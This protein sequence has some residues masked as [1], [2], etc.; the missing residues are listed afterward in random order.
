MSPSLTGIRPCEGVGDVMVQG[1]WNGP[2]EVPVWSEVLGVVV[3][4]PG[5]PAEVS[6]VAVEPEVE[7][8]W[9]VV[10]EPEGQVHCGV[11]ID[12]EEWVVFRGILA[13]TTSPR[14]RWNISIHSV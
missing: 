14:P 13:Q 6:A 3:E 7:V 11:V 8:P 1:L 4:V 2:Q 9:M 10:E 5:V 12:E